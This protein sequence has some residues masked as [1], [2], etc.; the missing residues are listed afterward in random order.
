MPPTVNRSTASRPTR[1][2]PRGSRRAPAPRASPVTIPT[3]P[4]PPT[5]PTGSAIGSDG[6]PSLTPEPDNPDSDQ[7]PP[8]APR[9]SAARKPQGQATGG[10]PTGGRPTGGQGSGG[11][12]EVLNNQVVTSFMKSL[13]TSLGGALGRSVFGTRRR[14]TGP[15]RQRRRRR[16]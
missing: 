4:T 8:P 1:C 2:S 6:W 14:L 12:G 16:A 10:R 9:P 5:V 15:P 11:I 7:T 3:V 13:G